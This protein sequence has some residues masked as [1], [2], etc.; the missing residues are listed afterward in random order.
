MKNIYFTLFSMML[1]TASGCGQKDTHKLESTPNIILVTLDC[2]RADRLAAYGGDP[3]WTPHLN[4]LA[5]KGTVFL[6]AHSAIGTTF[7]SHA[8][9]LTGFYPRYHGVR[10]NMHTL[11]K[12]F[13]TV[14][15]SLAEVGY[16]TG[17]FV[18]FRQMH[19]VGNLDQGFETI[20]DPEPPGAV[21]HRKGKETIAMAIDWLQ[22][23]ESEDDQPFFVW[24]H[25]FDA[26][27]P[28]LPTEWSKEKLTN[29]DG[30]F[31]DGVFKKQLQEYKHEI[32]ALPM[33]THALAMLYTGEVRKV[34][35]Q[36]GEL[37]GK[38]D[39]LDETSQSI[40]IAVVDHGQ[41]IGINGHTGHGPVLTEEILRVPLVITD[42]RDPHA[43][44]IKALV[45]TV[46][47]TPTILDIL[48][49]NSEM[50]FQGRSLAPALNGKSLE[51]AT[52]FAEVTP[53]PKPDVYGEWYTPNRVAVYDSGFK[54]EY[55]PARD[56]SLFDLRKDALANNELALDNYA[57]R[58]NFMLGLAKDYLS[59]EMDSQQATLSESDLETLKSLGYI[60]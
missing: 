57:T 1:L 46:D 28:H 37:M 29:Y 12:N 13:R 8:T 26:H 35:Q 20:S 24:V 47:L 2:F 54:L 5:S 38:L 39:S 48:G 59:R 41:G 6:N 52:Y 53:K 17:S 21:G 4:E 60:Q 10:S 22:D 19:T 36:F 18:S 34:D 42:L 49:I 32:K 9:M 11:P 31:K 45:G 40:V 25:L 15:E 7:P 58:L 50:H 51:P 33:E 44:R 55:D 23:I 30:M 43:Q 3:D 27:G 56:S 14:A 16:K